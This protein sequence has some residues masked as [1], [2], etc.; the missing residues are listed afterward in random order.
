MR[1]S[2]DP[3]KDFDVD[4]HVLSVSKLPALIKAL[5]C[6]HGTVSDTQVHANFTSDFDLRPLKFQK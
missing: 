3:G 1:K 6:S 4:L 2:M 5:T